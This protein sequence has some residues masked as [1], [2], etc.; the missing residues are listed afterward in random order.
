MKEILGDFV[1]T[2]K[3]NQEPIVIKMISDRTKG[4]KP[5]NMEEPQ[6]IPGLP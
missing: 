6:Q 3:Q 1:E 4:V 2:K 5:N